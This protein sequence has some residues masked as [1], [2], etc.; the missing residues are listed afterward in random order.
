[1]RILNTI[2]FSVFLLLLQS[3]FFNNVIEAQWKSV[4]LPDT[5]V[6]NDSTITSGGAGY[7]NGNLIL[8]DSTIIIFYSYYIENETEYGIHWSDGFIEQRTTDYG[9]TWVNS[10][11]NYHWLDDFF[12]LSQVVNDSTGWIYY[13]GPF[14]LTADGGET[15]LVSFPY[16]GGPP[17]SSNTPAMFFINKFVGWFSDQTILK[18]TDGGE[19]WN[20][21]DT[22]PY[23]HFYK[24][25][26]FSDENNGFALFDSDSIIMRTTNGGYSWN[27]QNINNTNHNILYKV[28]FADSNLGFIL[29]QN[30]LFFRTNDGGNTWE[31]KSS[32]ITYDLGFISFV[33]EN[34]GWIAGGNQISR[35]SDGGESWNKDTTFPSAFISDLSFTSLHNGYAFTNIGLLRYSNPDEVPVELVSFSGNFNSTEN[36]V[37]LNWSTATELSNY[38]FEIEKNANNNWQKIGFIKGAGNSTSNKIYS[39]E[40]KNLNNLSVIKYRLKQVDLDGT[41]KYSKT[42]EV[43]INNLPTEFKLAQ[44]YPNPFNPITII[45]YSIPAPPN[46]PKREALVQLKVYDIIG[47]EVATLV[48]ETKVPGNYEINFNGSNLASGVYFYKL[49]SNDFVSVKKMLLLK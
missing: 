31:K 18:T 17:E 24:S 2:R 10:L 34:D 26:Y 38:G 5:Y 47:N 22:L 6:F 1:M 35:T 43:S 32:G 4:T 44:N 40:D 9:N 46:L 36:V 16:T 19:A 49:V 13:N 25:L 45:K 28:S 37:Q 11:Y 29:S 14:Y 27:Q 30:G 20:T 41:Y 23:D 48:N 8:N 15:W 21:I 39:F 42:I 7:N 3:I 12:S 33:N